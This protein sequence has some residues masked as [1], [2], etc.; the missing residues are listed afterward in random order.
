MHLGVFSKFVDRLKRKMMTLKIEYNMKDTG[1]SGNSGVPVGVSNKVFDKLMAFWEFESLKLENVRQL[2]EEI[3]QFQELFEQ[4]ETEHTWQQFDVAI[5]RFGALTRGGASKFEQAFIT[6]I[7]CLK[8]PLLNSLLTDRTR[9]SGSTL[10]LIQEFSIALGRKF[11]SLADIFIPGILKLCSRSNKVFV[12]RARG[13]MGTILRESRVLNLIPKLKDALQN[14]SKPLRSSAAEF[15]LICME[16]NDK[17]ALFT[18]IEELEVAIRV[19]SVDS[20]QEVRETLRK[21]F[22]IYKEKFPDRVENFMNSLPALAKKYLDI[23]PKGSKTKPNFRQFRQS[24]GLDRNQLPKKED[25]DIIVYESPKNKSSNKPDPKTWEGLNRNPVQKTIFTASKLS[26]NES[27]MRKTPLNKFPESSKNM[28]KR[29]ISAKENL[30]MSPLKGSIASAK[31]LPKHIESSIDKKPLK[32][33]F[34][35]NWAVDVDTIPLVLKTEHSSKNENLKTSEIPSE[36]HKILPIRENNP[37]PPIAEESE[38]QLTSWTPLNTGH[39]DIYSDS[40]STFDHHNPFLVSN[41]EDDRQ[42]NIS[43]ARNVKLAPPSTPHSSAQ[44]M[45]LNSQMNNA[46]R[47]TGSVAAPSKGGA[48]RVKK[49]VLD[50]KEEPKSKATRVALNNNELLSN[51]DPVPSKTESESLATIGTRT[52]TRSVTLTQEEG[53]TVHSNNKMTGITNT[54]QFKSTSLKPSTNG[55]GLKLSPMV[56]RKTSSLKTSSIPKPSSDA[57]PSKKDAVPVSYENSSMDTMTT[58]QRATSSTSSS[59]SKRSIPNHN[60]FTPYDRAPAGVKPPP[61]RQGKGLPANSAL[62]KRQIY[63][64]KLKLASEAAKKQEQLDAHLKTSVIDTKIDTK[65]IIERISENLSQQ[66]SDTSVNFDSAN[67]RKLN[68]H[69]NLSTIVHTLVDNSTNSSTKA[70]DSQIPNTEP[71]ISNQAKSPQRQS[72]IDMRSDHLEDNRYSSVQETSELINDH[73]GSIPLSSNT[74]DIEMEEVKEDSSL[75]TPMIQDSLCTIVN[76]K[77]QESCKSSIEKD[78]NFTHDETHLFPHSIAEFPPSYD[79]EL[80][81]TDVN[82]SE[83]DRVEPIPQDQIILGLRIY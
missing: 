80:F 8:H 53:S 10:E 45:P 4:K 5:K 41:N 67:D 20:L 59:Q 25:I 75:I 58:R 3:K 69:E 29:E 22:L 9:L 70:E 83:V 61:K 37:L 65:E 26:K 23:A 63:S 31:N 39:S 77:E 62:A 24:L 76:E 11:E 47:N 15:M 50:S 14:Q 57:S 72:E 32:P 55:Q 82:M 30:N 21:V 28:T 68:A 48:Q 49:R 81:L 43:V 17:S 54:R 78:L 40:V 36:N 60:R 42:N 44:R 6:G 1:L 7:K 13:C 18:Q 52:G 71:I 46:R 74:Q 64:D 73:I 33:I 51:Q 27:E 35:N 34:E 79:M 66:S 38:P 16:L 2:E 12:N 56:T 19:G